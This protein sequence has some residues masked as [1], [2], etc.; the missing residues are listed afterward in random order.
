L[1]RDGNGYRH[2]QSIYGAYR[3]FLDIVEDAKCCND[4]STSLCLRLRVG[5]R[6]EVL[7]NV[8]PLHFKGQG[9]ADDT[10]SQFEDHFKH[11]QP[12]IRM[13][14]SPAS[15]CPCFK[16]LH[17]ILNPPLLSGPSYTRAVTVDKRTLVYMGKPG[18]LWCQQ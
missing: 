7:L 5:S 14:P 13:W 16:R 4:L 17:A 15:K 6:H 3:S 8:P 1:S 12:P 11:I 10:Q 18:N 9:R 2:H